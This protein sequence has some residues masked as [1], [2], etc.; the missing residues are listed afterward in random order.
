L[1]QKK[2]DPLTS[3]RFFAAAAIVIGHLNERFGSLGLSHLPLNQGVSFFFVLSGFILHYNYRSFA[4]IGAVKRFI[5]ARI[6]RIWPVHGACLILFFVVLPRN[7]WYIPWPRP[8][9]LTLLVPNLLL[10]QSW[11]P[12]KSFYLSLNGVSWS[13]S[14]ELFFYLALPLIVA[15]ARRP[16]AILGLSVGTLLLFCFLVDQ[17]EISC[18]FNAGE[19]TAYGLIYANPL[20]RICEFI[21]GVLAARMFL[22]RRVK[23]EGSVAEV[24]ALMAVVAFLMLCPLIAGM[25][26]FIAVTGS[27]FS[28]WCLNCGGVLFFALLIY[29][30][31]GNAGIISRVLSVRL[32]VF[33]GEISFSIYMTHQILNRAWGAYLGFLQGLP[34]I[35]EAA[36]FW[37]VLLAISSTMFLLI[38]TPARKWIVEFYDRRRGE[39]HRSASPEPASTNFGQ[40]TILS[41]LPHS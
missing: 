2:L 35:V 13:I 9:L 20:V 6:A 17:N 14:N 36:I 25:P 11:I 16:L 26:S 32:L 8:T 37:F 24:S 31:A 7:L 12:A 3:A 5:V 15:Y 33:L 27:A 22:E 10:V 40:D 1:Q 4:T 38:E 29:S 39:A 34:I 28:F 41:G 21:V 23:F 19:I 18:D 30:L